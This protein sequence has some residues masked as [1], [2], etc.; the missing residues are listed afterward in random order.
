M[1]SAP[2]SIAYTARMLCCLSRSTPNKLIINSHHN[3]LSRQNG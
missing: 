3:S 1:P 2:I